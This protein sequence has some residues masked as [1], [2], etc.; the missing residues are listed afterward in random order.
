MD[1]Q[2]ISAATFES[3]RH[4]IGVVPQET[5]LLNESIFYNIAYGKPGGIATKEEVVQAAKLARV[6]H[7]I[8]SMPQV[9]LSCQPPSA[10]VFLGCICMSVC[11]VCVFS[12][13]SVY[14]ECVCLTTDC[15]VL[16]TGL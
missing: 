10:C 3:L 5:T 6:H 2:C 8:M 13:C 11:L 1:G 12:V 4:G 9:S 14:A 16:C 7:T 15:F